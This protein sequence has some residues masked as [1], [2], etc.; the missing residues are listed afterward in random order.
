M[1]INVEITNNPYIQRVQIL[2]NGAAVSVYSNL[3]KFMDEP[4]AYWCDKI[5]DA[6]YEECNRSDFR[7]HF[8]SREEEMTVMGVLARNY[9]HCEQY[10]SSPLVRKDPLTQRMTALNKLIRDNK[11]SGYRIERRKAIIVVPESL[12]SLE[13]DLQEMEIKNAYCQVDALVVRYSDY[14][15]SK[16]SGDVTLLITKEK[17]TQECMERFDI[18]N[19]YAIHICDRSGFVEKRAGVFCYDATTSNFFDT[20]FNCFLLGPLMDVFCVC[21]KGLSQDIKEK[22]A[23]QIDIL[24]STSLKII[25]EPEKTNLEVGKSASI[26]F[27][28]DMEGYSANREKL[29]FDYSNKG[30]ITCNGVRVEGLREGKCTLY[31]YREGEQRPCAQVDYTV[32]KRNRITE[33]RMEESSVDMGSGEKYKLE[34][35]YLPDNADNVNA[36]IWESDDPSVARVDKLGNVTG[37]SVGKCTIRCMAEQVC[38]RTRVRVKPHLQKI[39]TETEEITMLYGQSVEVNYRTEPEDCIDDTIIVS[40]MDM[41]KVNVLGKTLKAVGLGETTVIIQNRQDTVRVNIKVRVVSEKE[42]KKEEKKQ[43]KGFFARL[44]G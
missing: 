6:I 35:T 38:A 27:K 28:T 8:Q 42:S 29:L 25:P 13:R 34:Y 3:E 24:Q 32:I 15:R 19:G 16:P 1:A 7:L 40:S 39:I 31:V 44:F 4:F 11:L 2:I 12:G 30:I 5:L 18:R 21:V 9:P 20:V 14:M 23:E 22:Y 10:T 17:S 36:I 43:K 33:I 37:V 26:R 41:M